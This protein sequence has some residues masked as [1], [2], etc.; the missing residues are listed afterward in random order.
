MLYATTRKVCAATP[1]S[2]GSTTTLQRIT[3]GKVRLAIVKNV[4][5]FCVLIK[6][7]SRQSLEVVSL[8]S[9]SSYACIR[10]IVRILHFSSFVHKCAKN[11]IP[12]TRRV[13][14]D[15]DEHYPCLRTC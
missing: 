9:G 4:R 3:Q 6:N 8:L 2:A 1:E 13:I 15:F 7:S 10:R 14:N 5:R 11:D 12:A